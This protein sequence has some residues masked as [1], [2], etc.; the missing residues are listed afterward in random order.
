MRLDR[1]KVVPVVQAMLVRRPKISKRSE[2]QNMSRHTKRDWLNDFS[3]LFAHFWYKDFPCDIDHHDSA[4]RADWTIHI[5]IA[6]RSCADLMGLF[7]RFESG[8]R[9]DAVLI[10]GNSDVVAALEWEWKPIHDQS[11]NELRKLN[12][13]T[14]PREFS[15]LITYLY[16][17]EESE[18]GAVSRCLSCWK[19]ESPLLLIL[20]HFTGRLRRF[21]RMT[22]HR[23][24][25]PGHSKKLR[26]QPA[27]AWEVEG[28]RWHRE[29]PA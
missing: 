7:A 10:D 2:K 1:H 8:G 29:T 28:S 15:V 5:G 25:G 3:V 9:T 6:V 4:G 14:I 24:A 20:V 26:E 19:N 23:I 16:E 12:E 21:T 13:N 18:T 11:A 22:F 17:D 27:I